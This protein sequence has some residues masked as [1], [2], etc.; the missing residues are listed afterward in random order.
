MTTRT[1][2]FR[3]MSVFG[4]GDE[5]LLL[6]SLNGTEE[7][8]RPFEFTL[9]CVSEDH[10]VVFEDWLGQNISIRLATHGGE[11]ERFL[12]G[13]VSQMEQTGVIGRLAT[14]RL[15]MVPFIW[16]L[17][18]K[19]DCRIFQEMSVPEIVQELIKEK[20][21]TDIEERL[22]RTYRK[23]DYCVQYR[24]T[25][26]NFI[27][28]LMEQ[29]GI[30]Y[31]FVHEE[32]KH[33]LV[34]ADD[35]GSHDPEEGSEELPFFPPGAKAV[36]RA[37]IFHWRVR[38]QI[39]TTAYSTTDYNFQKPKD[40]LYVRSSK[41]QAHTHGEIEI[42]D[43]P[44]DHMEYADG[45]TYARL[46]SEEL[47][48][49]YETIDAQTTSRA[50]AAGRIFTLTGHPRADQARDYLIVGTTLEAATDAYD[51]GKVETDGNFTFRCGF[52]CIPSETPYRRPCTTPK[53]VI[54]G[55]QTAFVTGVEGEEITTDEHGRV[56]VKFHWDLYSEANEK[57]SCWLRVS[58]DF[59]GKKWG[60][61]YVPRRG[62]EVIVTFLEGDPD[63]PLITGRVYN[64][65]N[66]PAY[67][68]KAQPTISGIKT[69]TIKGEGFNEIRFDDKAGHEQIFIHAQKDMDIRVKE[70]VR[71]TVEK[72]Y[73]FTVESN[74]HYKTGGDHHIEAAGNYHE[75]VCGDRHIIADGSE[76]KEVG[77]N[78]DL[79]VGGSV[80]EGVSGSWTA[81]VSGGITIS[82]G[83][84]IT[85][86]VGGTSLIIDAGGVTINTSGN[87][88][89]M[90]GGST[91][92]I[93]GGSFNA[94]GSSATMSGSTIMLAAPMVQC[95]GVAQAKVVLADTAV[96][97]AAFSPG[98]G[99]MV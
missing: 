79:T 51:G 17:S 44:G 56:K 98:A 14:Y 23:W 31:Y 36:A 97:S 67:D 96:V 64:G 25:D 16:L 42:F 18:R 57:S 10:D 47:A 11:K 19:A 52:D 66:K 24:E 78:Q 39:Q 35:R 63:K 86:K 65:E 70:N 22:S 13:I 99:N 77:G 93:S 49:A 59:A 92:F 69:C 88:N 15:V 50:A 85:L 4:P 54:A 43:F 95:A 21:F 48:V 27:S 73:H 2:A 37:H 72:E 90:A 91:N 81:D 94:V 38:K 55:P 33:T 1:Q 29:E 32:G 60:S 74:Y 68:P 5:V 83:S 87:V 40:D 20:G 89:S 45:E 62:Q 34:L 7:M 80:T 41:A 8:G 6:R 3:H 26:L 71:H 76:L 53:P 75:T 9:E 61:M 46:R 82:S 12:N 28:R 30:Y 84:K 58:Q